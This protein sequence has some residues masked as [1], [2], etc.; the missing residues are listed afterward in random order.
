VD[1]LDLLGYV[2]RPD[3]APADARAVAEAESQKARSAGIGIVTRAH[4]SF[5]EALKQGEE[6][7]LALYYQGPFEAALEAP[8]VAIVGSREATPRGRSIAF[9]LG[10]DL[11]REGVLVISGLARG[12]DTAAH[13]GALAGHGRTLAVQGRGLDAVYPA[14]NAGLARRMLAAGGVLLSEFPLGVGPRPFHFPKRNR[15]IAGL[16]RAVVVVEATEKSGA[17]VTARLALGRS[18]DV[19]AVPGHP[20]DPRAAGT[21]ALLYDGAGLVRHAQDVLDAIGD[22]RPAVARSE[23][24][25]VLRALNDTQSL[26]IEE[27]ASQTGQPTPHLL[28]HLTELELAGRVARLPGPVFVRV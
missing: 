20:F 7:P 15:L 22:I 9:A 5:P 12:I 2:L 3:A 23:S 26:S 1:A 27:L 4:R 13:E 8:A 21:N 6:P 11:A 19:L 10:R 16:A 28:A 25:P 18:V 24:D 17:L 14:E